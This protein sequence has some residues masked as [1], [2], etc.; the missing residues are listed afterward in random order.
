LHPSFW[1][2]ASRDCACACAISNA[3][4][5]TPRPEPAEDD[6]LEIEHPEHD[7]LPCVDF[8]EQVIGRDAAWS[9]ATSPTTQ[10]RRP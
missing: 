7:A 9:N 1:P 4:R 2:N 8:S 10:P 5:A 6:P 3:L